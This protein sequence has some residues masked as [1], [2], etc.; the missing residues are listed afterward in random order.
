[1][2]RRDFTAGQRRKVFYLSVLPEL[3]EVS[4]G[5]VNAVRSFGDPEIVRINPVLMETR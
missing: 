1:M 4:A 3:R 2:K 5:I